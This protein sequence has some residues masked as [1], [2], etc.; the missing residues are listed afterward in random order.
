MISFIVKIT[1]SSGFYEEAKKL[2]INVALKTREEQGCHTYNIHE[3]VEPNKSLYVYEIFNTQED[4]D[5]HLSREYTKN[6]I[7]SLEGNMALPVEITNLEL[8]L[9]V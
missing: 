3:S 6:F 9:S 2:L 1:P 8:I 5:F 4:F 7:G